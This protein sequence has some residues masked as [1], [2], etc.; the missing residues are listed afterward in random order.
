MHQGPDADSSTIACCAD[1]SAIAKCFFTRGGSLLVTGFV[2]TRPHLIARAN[3]DEPTPAMF[4][5]VF[6]LMGRGILVLR[7]WPPLFSNRLHS[8][9]RCGGVISASGIARSSGLRYAAC[10]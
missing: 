1:V 10:S 7:V 5:T 3:A 4:R 9:L 8:R 2:A 6:G